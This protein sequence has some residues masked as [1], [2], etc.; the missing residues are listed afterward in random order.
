MQVQGGL[1]AW[2]VAELHRPSMEA[3]GLWIGN[4]IWRCMTRHLAF[5]KSMGPSRSQKIFWPFSP[6]FPAPL[7]LSRR[8]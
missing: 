1:T 2:A 8:P 7:P 6:A 3:E 5:R 4:S